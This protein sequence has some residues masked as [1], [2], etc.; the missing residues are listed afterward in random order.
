MGQKSS[1]VAGVKRTAPEE[2]PAE[3]QVKKPRTAPEEQPAEEA[4]VK[5]PRP[6]AEPP[7][8]AQPKRGL[9]PMMIRGQTNGA[10]AQASAQTSAHAPALKRAATGALAQGFEPSIQGTIPYEDVTRQIANFIFQY[11]F[12]VPGDAPF[13]IEA[14]VGV[15]C[16]PATRNRIRLPVRSE[17]IVDHDFPFVFTSQMDEKYHRVMNNYLNGCLVESKRPGSTS[18]VP[19]EYMHLK[20]IDEFYEMT[21]EEAG[22][23][24]SSAK[25]YAGTWQGSYRHPRVRVTRDERTGEVKAKIVKS[26]LADMEV[27]CPNQAFDFRISINLE[28]P[29]MGKIDSLE[30]SADPPRNKDRLS[31]TH[32]WCR[33]DLTQV[34]GT[35]GAR[36]THELEV[37]LEMGRLREEGR[38]AIAQDPGSKYEDLIKVFLDNVRVLAR[39]APG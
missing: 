39:Y 31:Y 35:P 2:Q 27:Y 29:Y 11:V 8:W 14:K 38:L 1:K 9:K 28:Q 18:R 25:S 20:E 6:I 12:K 24:N 34:R 5:K 30:R 19:M 37:E 10:P 36:P 32:Q 33:M 23:Y 4:A 15:L 7:I 26:R 17:T 16:D 22:A 21:T 3:T 13:E